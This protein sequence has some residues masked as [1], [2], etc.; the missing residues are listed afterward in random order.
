MSSPPSSPPWP[1]WVLAFASDLP[2][3]FEACISLPSPTESTPAQSPLVPSPPPSPELSVFE[4]AK[5]GSVS[6]LDELKSES[7]MLTPE[8]QA[9]KLATVPWLLRLPP[10]AWD[11][12][13]Q[14]LPY[15]QVLKLACLSSHFQQTRVE[16]FMPSSSRQ[17]FVMYRER[18]LR[19]CGYSEI[20]ARS[21]MACYFCYTIKP[22][23]AFP[24]MEPLQA[25]RR[26]CARNPYTGRRRFEPLDPKAAAPTAETINRWLDTADGDGDGT[27]TQLWRPEAPGVAEGETETLRRCCT[28]CA[29]ASRIIGPGEV[30]N[31]HSA[32]GKQGTRKWA[33][34]CFK[35][36]EMT[37]PRCTRCSM[38]QAP[39]T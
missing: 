28:N 9:S 13:G 11:I 39:R 38:N 24:E 35:A 37:V 5:P 14:Y 29:I 10:R 16:N 4:L 6:E 32:H 21:H 7:E 26:V 34:Y 23:S 3:N 8:Q 19:A 18:D 25:P 30:F 15:A 22:P 2:P 1:P 33:C 20:E 12:I 17:Y 36:N 27:T 31:T